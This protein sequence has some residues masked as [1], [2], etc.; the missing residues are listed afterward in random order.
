MAFLAASGSA[1]LP[2][3][4]ARSNQAAQLQAHGKRR[5]TGA[6]K[7]VYTL[8]RACARERLPL[9]VCAHLL[10]TLSWMNVTDNG[11]VLQYN[12]SRVNAWMGAKRSKSM[13]TAEWMLLHECYCRVLPAHCMESRQQQMSASLTCPLLM[14][15]WRT[16]EVYERFIF[17]IS[18]KEYRSKPYGTCI[19]KT[20][21]NVTYK[22]MIQLFS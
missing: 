3:P 19:E 14:S 17:Y 5:N 18:A 4:R 16:W 12:S 21:T 6:C 20:I 13:T 11:W 9:P 8:E 1:F 2:W 15:L 7:S 22:L 10:C